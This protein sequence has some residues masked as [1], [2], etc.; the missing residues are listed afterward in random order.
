MMTV[1]S[2]DRG[3]VTV[4]EDIVGIVITPI[5]NIVTTISDKSGDFVAI[6]SEHDKLIEENEQLRDKVAELEKN[7]RDA[8]QAHLEN[9]ALKGMLDIKNNNPDF[10]FCPALVV[11]TDHSG[12]SYT[13]TLNAGSAD[14]IKRRDVVMTPDG[15]AGYVAE[16]GTTWCK[17]TTILDSSCEMGVMITRTQD[18]G[19]LEGDFSLASDGLCKVSYLSNDVQLS[20]GDS[21]VTS[22]IGGIFPAGLVIGNV[23]ELKPEKHGISQYAVTSPAVDIENLENV[24][25]ITSFEK[26]VVAQTQEATE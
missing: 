19:V 8:E 9:E 5:Q 11:A 21:I 7:M 24:F 10:K 13:V 17:V 4:F 26:D 15:V 18:I 23:Q 14:G 2:V 6:F 16:V 22:G 3:K 1:S 12:Y 20:S 25:V